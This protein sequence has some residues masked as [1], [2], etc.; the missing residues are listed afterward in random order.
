MLDKL[1]TDIK[2]FATASQT[3]LGLIA[4]IMLIVFAV[5]VLYYLLA[6]ALQ[7]PFPALYQPVSGDW[8]KITAI[9]WFVGMA[10]FGGI[11]A[12]ITTSLGSGGFTGQ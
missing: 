4:I 3:T 10:T 8:V 9:T 12:L 11:Y 7:G 2:A 5:G 1:N 6:R